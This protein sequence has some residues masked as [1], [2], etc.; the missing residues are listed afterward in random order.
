MSQVSKKLNPLATIFI[1]GA[2]EYFISPTSPTS[3]NLETAPKENIPPPA[4]ELLPKKTKGRAAKGTPSELSK[5]LVIL[6]PKESPETSPIKSPQPQKDHL[7]F[8]DIQAKME[9]ATI[10]QPARK[11]PNIP[12]P[13]PDVKIPNMTL[14]P[15]YLRNEKLK[16]EI[17]E[18]AAIERGRIP[19]AI[20]EHIARSA[21]PGSPPPHIPE[22]TEFLDSVEKLAA[23]AL[24]KGF[25][26]PLN[27]M[28]NPNHLDVWDLSSKMGQYYYNDGLIA[29]SDLNDPCQVLTDNE[30]TVR[31]E[32]WNRIW[33]KIR[34]DYLH[35]SYLPDPRTVALHK[36]MTHKVIS[37]IKRETGN[38]KKEAERTKV[39]TD[40]QLAQ[41]DR[42]IKERTHWLEGLGKCLGYIKVFEKLLLEVPDNAMMARDWF[43]KEF[44]K[45]R[46]E[47]GEDGDDDDEEAA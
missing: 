12:V 1:P 11:F 29:A 36:D 15:E 16:K 31:F 34:H 24:E 27:A 10:N 44:L 39:Y 20:L 40:Q 43:D 37:V 26:Q 22:F 41:F 4:P 35:E 42:A 46:K 47:Y 8:G 19:A 32:L 38:V 3:S 28:Y 18:K 45:G 13:V 7:F 9:K 14:T 25:R 33:L 6:A 17:A 2:S 23:R 30:G 21:R 5:V